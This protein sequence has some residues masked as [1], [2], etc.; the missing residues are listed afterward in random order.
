MYTHSTFMYMLGTSWADHWPSGAG[1]PNRH[2]TP[3]GG[4]G[5]RFSTQPDDSS[6]TLV[7]HIVDES[8]QNKIK[9]ADKFFSVLDTDASILARKHWRQRIVWNQESSP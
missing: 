1:T 9:N 3:F 6:Y 8:V 7:I 4:R 2:S 5:L